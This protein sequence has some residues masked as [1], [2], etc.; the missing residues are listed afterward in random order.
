MSGFNTHL[1]IAESAPRFHGRLSSQVSE[2][3]ASSVR[4]AAQSERGEEWWWHLTYLV[5]D[6]L[7]PAFE[8]EDAAYIGDLLASVPMR[9]VSRE[10]VGTYPHGLR[11]CLQKLRSHPLPYG[12]YHLLIETLS[13]EARAKLLRHSRSITVDLL[14]VLCTIPEECLCAKVIGAVRTRGQAEALVYLID[15]IRTFLPETELS[16][17][18]FSTREIAKYDDLEKWFH[19]WLTEA[20][21][22]TPPWQGN[23][24]LR[25]IRTATDLLRTAHEFQNCLKHYLG[26]CVGNTAAFYLWTA[27]DPVVVGLCRDPFLGWVVERM[28]GGRHARLVSDTTRADILEQFLN[29]GI[30]KKP[31]FENLDFAPFV[32]VI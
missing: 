7:G 24:I 22:P 17:L 6:Y 12:Y 4:F 23:A 27:G 15:A 13:D 21:F 25:P 28:E 8:N 10:I 20:P 29:A 16:R 19:S 9:S 5:V 11:N 30:R 31:P 3:T 32:E 18:W 26:D 1:T 2:L 14:D